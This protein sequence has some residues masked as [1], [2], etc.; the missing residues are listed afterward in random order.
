MS[1]FIMTSSIITIALIV[2]L[3]F[4]GIFI[5]NALISLKNNVLRNWANIDVLLKQ[6]N[7]E[8]PKLIETCQQYMEY[9]QETLQRV[10]KARQEALTAHQTHNLQAIGDTESALRSLLG[11]LFALTENY[12]DL[13]SNQTFLQLHSRISDLEN[14]IADRRELYNDSVNVYNIKIAQIPDII[15]ARL[16]NFAPYILLSFSEEEKRDISVKS[17]FKK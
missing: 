12:P 4:Y 6:R 7:S 11:K 13:K 17:I 5:F 8:I 3:L 15:M 2:A 14:S 10:V 9:E 16:F 1:S